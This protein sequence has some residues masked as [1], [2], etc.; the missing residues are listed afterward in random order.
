MRVSN[1]KN[2]NLRANQMRCPPRC[3]MWSIH[4]I[5]RDVMSSVV[6][7]EGELGENSEEEH[8]ATLHTRGDDNILTK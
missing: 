7:A 3:P 2:F 1:R 6:K 5:T 4:C 8:E